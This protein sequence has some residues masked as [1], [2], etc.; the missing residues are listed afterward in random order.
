MANLALTQIIP[1]IFS[2]ALTGGATWDVIVVPAGARSVTISFSNGSLPIVPK[3]GHVRYAT[4]ANVF[5]VFKNMAITLPVTPGDALEVNTGAA[6]TI[7]IV[8][9]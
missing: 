5:P 2:A 6:D 4:D 8:V 7:H 1:N 3:E 9:A